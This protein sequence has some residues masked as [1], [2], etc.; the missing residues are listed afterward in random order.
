MAA[1]GAELCALG[2]TKYISA[3]I[4]VPGGQLMM[5]DLGDTP[6]PVLRGLP[7]R[8]V[9]QLQAAGVAEATID[10]PPRMGDRYDVIKA[11]VPVAPPPSPLPAISPPSPQP[12]W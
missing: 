5:V 12:R 6:R 7:D 1:F 10:V 11:F 4:P 9:N 8:L 2:G 3:P